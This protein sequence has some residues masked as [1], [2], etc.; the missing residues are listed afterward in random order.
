MPRLEVAATQDIRAG[1]ASIASSVTAVSLAS[2]L[3]GL[4]LGLEVEADLLGDDGV[5]FQV[6]VDTG[7]AGV[8][9]LEG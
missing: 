8:R 2:F 3:D 9:A 6:L 4:G 5:A 7:A 1:L